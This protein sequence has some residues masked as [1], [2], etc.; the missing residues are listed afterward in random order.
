[1]ELDF[2]MITIINDKNNKLD[3]DTIKKDIDKDE[4]NRI[5]KQLK[6]VKK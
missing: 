2:E 3:K 1:M 4:V 6:K 5:L